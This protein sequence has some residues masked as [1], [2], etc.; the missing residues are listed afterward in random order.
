M[1]KEELM[2]RMVA[3]MWDSFRKIIKTKQ[4][5]IMTLLKIK[6]FYKCT[7]KEFK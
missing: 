1:V 3:I 6:S 5:N 2:K 4:V 7:K